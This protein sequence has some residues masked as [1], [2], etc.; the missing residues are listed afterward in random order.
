MFFWFF[1]T[2]QKV[3]FNCFG[4][5]GFRRESLES[6]SSAIKWS[7]GFWWLVVLGII[8]RHTHCTSNTLVFF[9]YG[10]F[11]RRTIP[12]ISWLH[13]T[14]STV[15]ILNYFEALDCL[16]RLISLYFASPFTVYHL[17]I[18]HFLTFFVSDIWS[19]ISIVDWLCTVHSFSDNSI[20]YLFTGSISLCFVEHSNDVI[21][22]STVNDSSHST[23]FE[24][25]QPLLSDS[26]VSIHSLWSP[27][28][29][30]ADCKHIFYRLSWMTVDVE[31]DL[32]LFCL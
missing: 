24:Y 21:D 2:R 12:R 31:F 27:I 23:R 4:L 8:Y 15:G 14:Q 26:T 5:F 1:W 13:C 22:Q 20:L 3:Q 28:L 16:N 17:L 19:W 30:T 9:E 25:F 32:C 6:E 11:G 18:Y 10:L 29:F 7:E